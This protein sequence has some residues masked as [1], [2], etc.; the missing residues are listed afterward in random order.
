MGDQRFKPIGGMF[1]GVR[2]STATGGEGKF[3]G[4]L[5]M[6]NGDG[7]VDESCF[8]EDVRQA[9]TVAEDLAEE[10][11]QRREEDDVIRS[12]Y[13][14]RLSG[15]DTALGRIGSD[16][17]SIRED[18]SGLEADLGRTAQELSE[19]ATNFAE[20]SEKTEGDISALEERVSSAEATLNTAM[21]D[22]SDLAL[23]LQNADEDLE[24]HA[25]EIDELKSN[26]GVVATQLANLLEQLTS[27]ANSIAAVTT[28]FEAIKA[29]F[30]E[31]RDSTDSRFETVGQQIND[32]NVKVDA[33]YKQIFGE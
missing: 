16:V 9:A 18:V 1:Q 23:G 7:L 14:S 8:P 21:H 12:Q 5:V 31:L 13:D 30:D 2:G 26:S 10:T 15:V 6:L 33:I 3:A 22:I 19:V 27:Y 11:R 28:G 17:A 4:K 32:L 29:Q 25:R 20:F 24:N